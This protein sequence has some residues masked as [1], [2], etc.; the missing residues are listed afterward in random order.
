[1]RRTLPAGV[2]TG[3]AALDAELSWG[4]WPSE[5][6]CELLGEGLVDGFGL[7]LPAL[8]RLGANV[9][10][11]LLVD[12]PWHPFAPALAARGLALDRLVVASPG[13]G[14]A[15]AA[16]QGLRSGACAAVLVWGGCWDTAAL[17]RLQLAAESGGALAFLFRDS[18]TVRSHSPAP[19]RLQ[20][21]AGV[22]SGETGYRVRVL[23]QRG[24]PAGA[25]L[26][27]SSNSAAMPL[28]KAV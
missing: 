17:R 5:G 16:E 21:S 28:W 26:S 19:L 7:V 24:G 23:K 14:C 13:E 27:L 10:W 2:P 9:R 1:M 3:F 6:L 11:L 25:L 12:P 15:W 4:G 8:V 20:V 22:V 18:T